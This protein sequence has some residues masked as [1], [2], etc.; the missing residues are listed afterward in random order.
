MKETMR[1]LVQQQHTAGWVVSLGDGALSEAG[2]KRASRT[3]VPPAAGAGLDPRQGTF[4]A[5]EATHAPPTVAEGASCKVVFDGVLYNRKE[6]GDRFEASSSLPA[7]DDADLILRAYLHWGEDLLQKVKGIFALFIWDGRRNV[8][9]CARDP[10][11]VYPLF[12]ADTGRELVL[13][14]SIEALVQ[15]QGVSDAVNRPVLAEYLCDRMENPEETFYEAIDR[16]PPGHAMRVEGTRRQ[17]Y[18]YWDPLPDETEVDWIGED[19]LERF[20]EL[21][22]QA[23][24]RGLQL[25]QAGIFLSGGLDS[26]SVAAVAAA[27]ARRKGLPD[28]WALS[29]VFPHPEVNEET[30]QRYVGSSL[31]LRHELVPYDETTGSQGLLGSGMAISSRLPAP[32]YSPWAPVYQHLGLEGKRR[33]CRV[34]LTGGGGDEWLGV[35]PFYAADLLRSLDIGGLYRLWYTSHRSYKFSRL[36]FMYNILWKFGARP[37]IGV[38]ARRVLRLTAPEVLHWRWRR[39][40]SQSTPEWVAPDRALRQEINQRAEQRLFSKPD[41]QS[42]YFNEARLP[43]EHPLISM[44][45]E[46]NFENGRRMGLHLLMPYW[47]ADL[48]AFLYRTPPELLNRGNR[49]KAMVRQTVARR[50]PGMNFERQKKVQSV[51]FFS[52]ILAEEVPRLWQAMDGAPALAELGIVYP[53]ALDSAV[54]ELLRGTRPAAQTHRIR[55]ILFIEAW[56]RSRLGLPLPPTV[57]ATAPLLS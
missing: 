7:T 31:G 52:S 53:P 16:V 25:G 6:L 3:R 48:V 36:A 40:I 27:A 49:T 26:T 57:E 33:G 35:S 41:P 56:L 23:V 13:S 15:H 55:D 9:L 50:F 22:E 43:L 42:F 10:L 37:W 51:N 45:M 32:L 44:E 18:R 54:R 12:Y 2:A 30:R 39:R 38:A 11:G 5:D 21:L 24:G 4:P 29:I 34:I 46:E 20:D 8:L 47:D 17:V 1:Q 28:P 14:T 19:E